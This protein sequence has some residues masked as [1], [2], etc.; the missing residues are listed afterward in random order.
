LG[1]AALQVHILRKLCI[2]YPNIRFIFHIEPSYIP[3]IQKHVGIF[4]V[5]IVLA[6][7]ADIPKSSIDCWI[8]RDDFYYR[9]PERG[10]YNEVYMRFCNLMC[11]NMGL[12]NP[13]ISPQSMLMDNEEIRRNTALSRGY[14]Y[15]I[16]NSA[17]GSGQFNYST[18]EFAQYIRGLRQRGHRVIT[19]VKIDD[20]PCTRDR[21]LS[22]LEIGNVSLYVKKIIAIHTAPI[23][24]TFNIWNQEDT[25]KSWIVF[26][27]T[28]GFTYNNRIKL[29]NS[30]R[31]IL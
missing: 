31:F 18:E 24:G 20:I 25:H 5:H 15:L 27:N 2:L 28:N 29:Y 23:H 13:I 12:K 19:T 22:L 30:L 21:D 7:L 1:D 9:D 10:K 17:P 11:A 6:D 8:G 16:I 3:E 4:N 14:D 26:D